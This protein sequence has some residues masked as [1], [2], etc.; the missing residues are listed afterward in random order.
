M[1]NKKIKKEGEK[2]LAITNRLNFRCFIDLTDKL[3][4]DDYRKRLFE[5]TNNTRSNNI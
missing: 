4:K 2:Y 3:N 1:D 5:G